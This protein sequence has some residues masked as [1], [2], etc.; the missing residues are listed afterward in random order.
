MERILLLLVV[1]SISFRINAQESRFKEGETLNIW[2]QSGLNMRNKPDA[3]A[4]KLTTIPYGAKVIVQPNI[5]VKI[6]FE[7]EEF[8]GFIVKGY[9]LLVKYGNTEGFVFDGFLSRLPAPLS[10]KNEKFENY[11]DTNFRKIGEKYNCRIYTENDEQGKS[12]DKCNDKSINY[13]AYSQKYSLKII[14]SASTC[15]EIGNYEV[16][17]I[18]NFTLYEG[19]FWVKLFYGLDSISHKISDNKKIIHLSSIIKQGGFSCDYTIEKIGTKIVI[20]GYC[21]C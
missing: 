19:L 2:A 17:E 1:L 6:P 11:F 8:K 20:K 21:S 7:V 4:P 5:G 15:N 12:I 10:L 18:E 13:C 14:Y 16:I 9:W 3:K